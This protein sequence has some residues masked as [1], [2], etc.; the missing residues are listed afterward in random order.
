MEIKTLIIDDEAPARQLLN[1]YLQNFSDVDVVGECKDGF[2]ALKSI[3]ELQPQLIFLDIQM[4]KLTGLELLEI[5]DNPP[6]IIF[7]T[8]YDEYAIQAFERNAVD[9]L[10]KPFSEKRLEEAINR[11]RRRIAGEETTENFQS[12]RNDLQQKGDMLSRVVVKTGNK[13]RIIDI[14]EIV[15]L[16]AQDDYVM[17]HLKGE[18]HLKQNTMRYFEL[19]LDP[20]E[21][22]RTHRSYIVRINQIASIE[23][24]EK[25]SYVVKLKDGNI[26]PVSRSGYSKLKE[27][28]SF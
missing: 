2:A 21:F 3:Q 17:L 16:E 13:I 15:Y 28:L 20:H 1:A 23:L 19:H 11:A 27:Q 24:Y 22:V 9:Y 7:T 25:E 26:L 5:L 12:L 4:P 14:D 8:A 18:K 6:E 10:L